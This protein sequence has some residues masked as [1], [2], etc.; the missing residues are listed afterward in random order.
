MGNRRTESR[1]LG[2]GCRNAGNWV[3]SAVNRIRNAGNQC[4]NVENA[5]NNGGGFGE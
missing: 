2:N 5:G 3:D 1:E 4:G